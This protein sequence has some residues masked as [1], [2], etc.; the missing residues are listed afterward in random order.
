M[1]PGCFSPPFDSSLP[2]GLRFCSGRDDGVVPGDEGRRAAVYFSLMLLLLAM[3]HSFLSGPHLQPNA[4]PE[5]SGH[6]A[7]DG[8]F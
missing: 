1:I 7:P 3:L 2:Y 8:R 5:L 6:V 4:K